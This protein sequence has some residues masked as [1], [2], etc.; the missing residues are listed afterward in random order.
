MAIK[1][2]DII[3]V[4]YEGT[5]E[6]GDVFDSTEKNGGVPLK[7]EVGAKQ[8]IPGFDDAVVGKEVGEEITVKIEPENAYGERKPDL[9]QKVPLDKFPLGDPPE[10]GKMLILMNQHG[11]QMFA[12]IKEVGEEDATLDLN[13]PLAGKVLNFNIKIIETRAPEKLY[14]GVITSGEIEIFDEIELPKGLYLGNSKT[15]YDKHTY[16]EEIALYINIKEK[17]LV[18][19]TGCSHTGII[20]IIKH[21]Q[22]LTGIDKVYA[23]I[24]GFHEEWNPIEVIQEKVDYLG[25]LKPE[26]TCGMHCTGFNFN[27]FMS[28]HP[29]H[30]LGVVGTEFHL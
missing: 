19:I 8:L 22:K 10:P 2:G 26:I 23:V 15:E 3:K 16:R 13:H 14:E 30:T 17:G 28:D 29:S 20:N 25:E 9:T 4:E 11:H 21:G 6:D 24:G 12:T 1:K 5:L 7:F 18:I 27:K